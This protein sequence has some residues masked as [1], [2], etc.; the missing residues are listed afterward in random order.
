MDQQQQT[1]DHPVESWSMA[2][3]MRI[4][5]QSMVGLLNSWQTATVEYRTQYSIWDDV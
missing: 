4:N 5:H 2:Q 3:H 1:T